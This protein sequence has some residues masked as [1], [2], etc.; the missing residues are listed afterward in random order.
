[1]SFTDKQ[2]AFIQAKANGVGHAEAA[3]IAGYSAS[4]A[5]VTA[6]KLMARKDVQKAVAELR[7]GSSEALGVSSGDGSEVTDWALK[8]HYDSPLDLLID[9]MNNPQAPKSL[10]Y[11]AAKDALPYKH[12]RVEG[13]KKEDKQK[14][15]E[16]AAAKPRFRTVGRPSHL[17]NARH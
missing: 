3:K 15:A 1:M 8:D 7:A 17:D 14:S 9:V 2:K 4:S 10:R 6:T 5:A 16:K 11:T 13:S 12:G